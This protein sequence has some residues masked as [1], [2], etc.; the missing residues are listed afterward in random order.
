M[1]YNRIKVTYP[2]YALRETMPVDSIAQKTFK[3]VNS[4]VNSVI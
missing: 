2:E 1:T 3:K 4:N